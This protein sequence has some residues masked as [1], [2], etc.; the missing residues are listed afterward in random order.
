MGIISITVDGQNDFISGALATNTT[1]LIFKNINKLTASGI[2]DRK[3]ATGDKHPNGHKE[4]AIHGAHCVENTWGMEFDSRLDMSIM[5]LI[6]YKG[7]IKNNVS[8]SAFCDQEG[9]NTGLGGYMD[10]HKPAVVIVMGWV[11]GYCVKATA[12]DALCFADRVIVV[13]DACQPLSKE[14]ADAAVKE[15]DALGIDI[16]TTEEVLKEFGSD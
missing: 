7:Q 11:I 8:Y 4:F 9:N 6:L 12:I 10:A 5:D 16:M 2:V 1:E 15:M 14:N 3:V 13:I